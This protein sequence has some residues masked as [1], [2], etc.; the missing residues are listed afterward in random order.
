MAIVC[1]HVLRGERP[2][3][4]IWRDRESGTVGLACGTSGHRPESHDDW[5]MADIDHVTRSDPAMSVIRTLP[6]GRGVERDRI[7]A[8]WRSVRAR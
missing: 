4:L 7:G 5:A 1:L 3:L 8:P 6:R 2:V